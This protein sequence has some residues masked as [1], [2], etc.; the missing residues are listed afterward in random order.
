MKGLHRTLFWLTLSAALL[1][2]NTSFCWATKAYLTDSFEITL[3]TGPGTQ[4]RVSGAAASGAGLE[5]LTSQGEWSRVRFIDPQGENKEAWVS[6]RLIITRQPW[7]I[8]ARTLEEEN[9]RMKEKLSKYEGDTL[10]SASRVQQVSEEL[11]STGNELANLQ[12]QYERLKSGA[13]SYL[14]LKEEY[15]GSL[16]ALQAAQEKLDRITQENKELRSAERIRWFLAGAVVLFGGWLIGLTMGR[17]QKKRRSF[18]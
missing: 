16:I 10:A 3:R 18:Y 12:Q 13:S 15:E 11:Q 2:L 6:N 1:F 14:E 17:Y 9:A 4:Y 7:E 8:R 5:V